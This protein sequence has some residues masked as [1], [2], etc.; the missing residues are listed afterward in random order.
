VDV[1]LKPA[2]SVAP[3]VRR[4]LIVFASLL[5]LTLATVGVSELDFGR[6]AAI[7]VAVAIASVKAALVAM[8]FMHLS[9]ERRWM[10]WVI[11]FVLFVVINLLFWPAWEEYE[12]LVR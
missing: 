4:Y 2:E 8:V 9:H 10:Y 5:V 11:V 12:R 3:E 6:H 7:A 1:D